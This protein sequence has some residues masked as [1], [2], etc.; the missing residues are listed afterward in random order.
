LWYFP[1]IRFNYYLGLGI[2]IYFGIITIV[3]L[4]F[5]VIL[6]S[7]M[8]SGVVL[9]LIIGSTLHGISRT[10]LGGV[11]GFL[12]MLT[13]YFLGILLIRLRNK[14]RAPS[15][16]EA[17]GFGDVNLGGVL[18]LLLGWPGVIAGLILAVFSA[19]IVSFLYIITMILK[20]HYSS[21]LAIPYG[22]FLIFGTYLLIYFLPK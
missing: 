8:I 7:T 4:E 16:N 1:P 18:G 5:R 19:G 22:P 17:L 6:N 3:D 11:A 21:N 2:L 12:I 9:F 10:I 14:K 13:L 15:Y 20:R